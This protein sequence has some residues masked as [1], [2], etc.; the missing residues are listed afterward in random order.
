V[1]PRAA[2]LAPVAAYPPAAT[3]LPRAAP[4]TAA[5]RRW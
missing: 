3:L 1:Q 2:L 5:A 4:A